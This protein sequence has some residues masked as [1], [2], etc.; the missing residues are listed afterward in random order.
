MKEFILRFSQGVSISGEGGDNSLFNSGGGDRDIFS[1]ADLL[2]CLGA[3]RVLLRSSRGSAA[4]GI[5]ANFPAFEAMSFF[6][7]LGMLL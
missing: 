5:M 6:H 1:V 2:G 4:L 7:A 3:V